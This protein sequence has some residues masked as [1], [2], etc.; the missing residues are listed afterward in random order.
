MPLLLHHPVGVAVDSAGNLFIADSQNSRIRKVAPTG[1]I[2]TVAGR[3]R[4]GYRGDGGLAVHARLDSPSGVTVDSAGNLFIAD[5]GNNRIRKVDPA[6]VITTVAGTGA[7][8]YGGDGGPAVNAKLASP[9]GVATDG[10]GNLFIADEGN[11]RIRKVNSAG[12]IT[13]VAGTGEQGFG[14]DG[15]PAVQTP[16][17]DPVGVAVDSAGNLFIADRARN[18]IRKVDSAGVIT[19]VAGTGARGYGGDGGPAVRAQIDG[20][21]G[22]AT[23]RAGNLFI[24]DSDNNRIRRVDSAGVITTIAGMGEFGLVGDD[25][26]AVN[27]ELTFPVG[28]AADGAGNLFIAD[29]SNHRI[30]KVDPAGVITT[31]AGSGEDGFGGDGGPAVQAR[32]YFP[33]G[34]STD[35]MGNLF[36]AD[37]ENHRV[38]ILTPLATGPTLAT[39]LNSASFTA[40]VAP[41]SL[42]SLFGEHLVAETVSASALPLLADSAGVRVEIIDTTGMA[43]AAQL[44]LVSPGQVNFLIPAETS[45][46]TARLQLT[47]EGEAAIELAI[48]VSAVAPGYSRRTARARV[49]VRSR[50][51]GLGPTARAQTRRCSAT[52]QRRGR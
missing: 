27:A 50:R 44:L 46:G 28:V 14:K 49:L 15:G 10:A 43:R 8:G 39:V 35:G 6:G 52:M 1:V 40:A 12:V 23:D 26:P 42:A 34:V 24:A 48:T 30:R 13:T 21:R 2:T 18:R 51:S 33:R 31:V 38:R 16:L 11:F 9:D 20:P 22:V 41:N 36:I 47:R 25:G 29:T 37:R 32:L 7:R 3:E 45:P 5:E 17:W 4:W 19:T